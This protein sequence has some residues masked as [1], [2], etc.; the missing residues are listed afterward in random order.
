[1]KRYK[2][3]PE[4]SKFSVVYPY[5]TELTY[6]KEDWESDL[7][8]HSLYGDPEDPEDVMM[9]GDG[10][11][12][13]IGFGVEVNSLE[14]LDILE[15]YFKDF[16]ELSKTSRKIYCPSRVKRIWFTPEDENPWTPDG[17]MYGALLINS[18]KWGDYQILR[19]ALC[20]L[21]K[22]GFL[23]TYKEDLMLY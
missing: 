12:G 19:E 23:M 10:D 2:I 3:R 4:L 1:M 16:P 13:Y 14:E 5:W 15:R 17:E 6:D 7:V 18:I 20:D 8:T 11:S 21:W 9:R 22:I